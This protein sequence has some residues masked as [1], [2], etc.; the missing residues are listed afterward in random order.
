MRPILMHGLHSLTAEKEV[1]LFSEDLL[2]P[3]TSRIIWYATTKTG[4]HDDGQC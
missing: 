2:D 4:A 1:L 3:P